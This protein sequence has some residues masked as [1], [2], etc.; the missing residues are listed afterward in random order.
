MKYILS[1]II[2]TTIALTPMLSN[3]MGVKV[4]YGLL[5]HNA[6]FTSFPGVPTCCP[7]FEE[8]TGNSIALGFLFNYNI[9]HKSMIG[10]EFSYFSYNSELIRQENVILSGNIPGISEH[11]VEPFLTDFVISPSYNYKLFKDLWIKGGFHLGFVNVGTFSQIEQVV[12]PLTATYETGSS[13]RNRID[14]ENIDELLTIRTALN[15]GAFYN[16]P[17]TKDSSLVLAPEINFQYGLSTLINNRDW[18]FNMLSFGVAIKFRDSKSEKIK[19]TIPVEKPKEIKDDLITK[20]P[21]VDKSDLIES[22]KADSINVEINAVG[23]DNQG[24]EIDVAEMKI[25]EFLNF[26]AEP[27]LPYIFFDENSSKI[28]EKYRKL[29]RSEVSKFSESSFKSDSTLEIYYNLL[30]IVGKRL[31]DNSDAKITL[32]GTNSN[33]NSEENNL[34]LSKSRAQSVKDYFT[35]N[36]KVNANRIKIESSN[37]PEK[38]SNLNSDE[39]IEENRRVEIYSDNPA[40]TDIVQINDTLRTSNPP[41]IRFKPS[42]DKTP[43]NW[44]LQI[45]QSEKLLKEYSGNGSIPPIIDW[46]LED[47]QKTI[48]RFGE[49]ISAIFSASNEYD[50]SSK[51]IAT[52]KTNILKISEK[53]RQK[54]D[55]KFITE[56]NL[57]LF[58]FNSSKIENQNK[59][60]MKLVQEYVEEN[61]TV[62]IIGYTDKTGSEELNKNLSKN[63]A[64]SASKLL[65]ASNLNIESKGENNNLFPFDRPEGRMYARTVKIIIETPIKE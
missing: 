44:N 14:N 31:Q 26:R 49:S 61:S 57:I 18:K 46:N 21:V 33:S 12:D 38:Y 13:T 43:K 56:F 6:N 19:R 36:W 25:E 65:E 60:I 52:L 58:D 59:D 28:P 53:R 34:E 5:F 48:P 20:K 2:F 63:R 1:I 30:N 17:L 45:Y 39:G 10:A 37:L 47:E 22:K 54:I 62:K 23:L 41:S 35:K 29:N 42:S 51:E 64:E 50:I 8:G 32:V 7:G 9:N 27:L 11:K 15:F 16:F 3:E 55:D 4:N 40:I 24:Q